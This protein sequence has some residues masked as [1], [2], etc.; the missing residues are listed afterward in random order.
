MG[1]DLQAFRVDAL[2]MGGF[3]PPGAPAAGPASAQ[4]QA[5]QQ[6]AGF[7]TL[8]EICSKKASVDA[9]GQAVQATVQ[10][11]EGAAQ[12][13]GDAERASA[14]RALTAYGHL[15]DTVGKLVELTV[16]E[17]KRRRAASGK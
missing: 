17:I 2:S 6:D 13:G 11:L 16:A 10:R 14:A 8:Q 9:F 5:E 4:A 7:P 3:A 12:S 15:Q 1:E